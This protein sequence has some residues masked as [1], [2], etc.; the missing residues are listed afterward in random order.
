MNSC[1][2]CGRNV[3]NGDEF[4]FRKSIYRILIKNGIE[5][6]AAMA[7]IVDDIST[8]LRDNII[9]PESSNEEEIN[10][11]SGPDDADPEAAALD[12]AIPRDLSPDP[13][14]S[15]QRPTA[16]TQADKIAIASR[17]WEALQ[18]LEDDDRPGNRR[19]DEGDAD[20]D[21]DASGAEF[22]SG[23]SAGQAEALMEA[24]KQAAVEARKKLIAA[25][26]NGFKTKPIL[27]KQNPS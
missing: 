18:K 7:R 13:R 5:D 22:F 2:F 3:F 10:V 15:A 16:L 24:K 17:E 4:D 12:G 20:L 21:D 11:G 26:G 23:T 25:A 19:L 27:R 14:R 1:P 6:E 8:S 9:V